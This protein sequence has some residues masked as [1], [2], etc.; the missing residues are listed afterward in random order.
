M[1]ITVDTPHA[2]GQAART[3]R[4]RLGL[5]QPQ[6]ALAAGVGVRFIVDME[7]GK[8]TIRLEST[9][10]VLHALGAKLNVDGLPSN[11]RE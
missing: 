5:T 3:A 4:K 1:N 7:A 8:P 2:L 10:R 9:L 11:D 6:L